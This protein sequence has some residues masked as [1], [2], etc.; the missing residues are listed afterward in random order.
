MSALEVAHER[1]HKKNETLAKTVD[2][3]K[4]R[5]ATLTKAAIHGSEVVLGAALAG[6]IQ[7][8]HVRK[9]GD[10][11][12]GATIAGMPA[13]LVIGTALTVA[14]GLDVAGDTWSPHLGALGLGFLAGFGAE[15]GYHRGQEKAKNGSWFSRKELPAGGSGTK[16]SGSYNP[17]AMAEELLAARRQNAGT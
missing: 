10:K 13:D 4:A 6:A 2:R 14:S 3:F 1:L 11:H 15:W 5:G 17:S 9:E 7:G 16:S 8:Q 12:T